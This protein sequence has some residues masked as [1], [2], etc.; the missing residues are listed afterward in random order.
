MRHRTRRRRNRNAPP[1]LA[2][3]GVFVRMPMRKER[4]VRR[5]LGESEKRRS[6]RIYFE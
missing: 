5:Q 3:E 2:G 6:T 1:S 4:R